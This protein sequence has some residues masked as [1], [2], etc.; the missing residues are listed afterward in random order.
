MARLSTGARRLISAMALA[1]VIG[2]CVGAFPGSLA[3][4]H[5]PGDEATECHACALLHPLQGSTPT[6]TIST[7]AAIVAVGIARVP[8]QRLD[9]AVDAAM[10]SSRAPPRQLRCE[11]LS[12]AVWLTVEEKTWPSCRTG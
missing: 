8:A 11:S 12:I 4:D 7:G 6:V 5:H 3:H 10:V 9:G 2:L 1:A